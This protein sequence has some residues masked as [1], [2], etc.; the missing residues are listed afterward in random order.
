MIVYL[1]VFLWNFQQQCDPRIGFGNLSHVF[2]VAFFVR[3]ASIRDNFADDA[4][5]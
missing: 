4:I 2:T 3:R 1:N 5:G